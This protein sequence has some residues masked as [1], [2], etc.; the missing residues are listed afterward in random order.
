MSLA[1]LVVQTVKNLPAMGETWVRSWVGKSPW[2]RKWQ[3]IPVFLTGESSWTEKP[4]RLQSMESQRVGH[5]SATKHSTEHRVRFYKSLSE[6]MVYSPLASSCF[7]GCRQFP[8]PQHSPNVIN[9]L[10]NWGQSQFLKQM[11]WNHGLW[12]PDQLVIS[13]GV[14]ERIVMT[15]L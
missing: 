2:R 11:L 6:E 3:P 14:Y 12:V 5:D 1:S 4:G 10:N 8:S 9:L 15:D 13:Y 7:Q